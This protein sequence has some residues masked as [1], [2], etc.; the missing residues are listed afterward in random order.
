MIVLFCVAL[1]Q[2]G[3]A[4]LR[5]LQEAF[6]TASSAKISIKG[7]A[8]TRA[9]GRQN[10]YAGVF[11][12]KEGD[13]LHLSIKAS[14]GSKE[15]TIISD[16]SRMCQKSAAGLSPQRPAERGMA[17]RYRS[18]VFLVGGFAA[19]PVLTIAALGGV[20]QTLEAQDIQSGRDADGDFLAY[21]VKIG[22][23][24][25]RAKIKVWY[26]PATGKIKKRTGSLSIE[27][28]DL[29]LSFTETYTEYALNEA[30]A[31]SN[32]ILPKP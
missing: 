28:I 32:F 6:V 31:E 21:A 27:A 11:L 24:K 25:E 2:D 3:T 18:A 14:D 5:T 15:T 29:S 26:E 1:C 22:D 12:A 13:K 30:L 7:E 17:E 8:A 9:G 4:S 10:A 19:Q 16:G 20:G 23:H